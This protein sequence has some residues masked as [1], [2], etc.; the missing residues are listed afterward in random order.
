LCGNVVHLRLFGFD[1]YGG[2][3]FSIRFYHLVLEL[4]ILLA[5][6]QANLYGKAPRA[7]QIDTTV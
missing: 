4:G 2:D 5:V 1:L 3:G 6:L 7:T